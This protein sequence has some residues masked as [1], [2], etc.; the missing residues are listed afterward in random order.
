GG[1][2]F[3][4]FSF[5]P[6]KGNIASVL[7]DPSSIAL[8]E[9]AARTFFGKEE[10]LG[11][12]LRIDNNSDLKVSAVLADPPGNSSIQFDFVKSFNFSDPYIKQLMNEWVNS[13]WKVYLQATPGTKP[14]VLSKIVNKVKKQHDQN[15]VMSTYF[16][17]P[18]SKWRLHSEFK[19]GINVV[20]MIEY[21]RL[22]SI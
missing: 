21:V 14:Q 5:K 6:V 11:K 7:N 4:M 13:S 18:M 19:N 3:E 17:F 20:G 10:P 9:S 12:V 1:N 8:T 22:F 15:D 16:V 2:F